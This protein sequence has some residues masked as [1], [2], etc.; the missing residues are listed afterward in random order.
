MATE[1]E[2]S[3]SDQG[4]LAGHPSRNLGSRAKGYG[5]AAGYEKPLAQRK[6]GRESAHDIYGPLPHAGY[7]GSGL[8]S[9]GFERG[10]AGFSDELPWYHAQYGRTSSHYVEADSE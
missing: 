8:D 2:S 4:N 9:R 5:V 10:Q 6:A 7:Y 1:H 3:S